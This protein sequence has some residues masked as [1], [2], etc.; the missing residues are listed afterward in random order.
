[1]FQQYP[2]VSQFMTFLL[3]RSNLGVT[4]GGIFTVG[5]VDENWSNVLNQ[6][7]VPV[8]EAV[9]EWI[10]LSDGIIVDGQNITGNGFL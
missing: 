1:M 8:L 7:Q 10:T 5:E 4:D 9:Q 3:S 6:P 2:N